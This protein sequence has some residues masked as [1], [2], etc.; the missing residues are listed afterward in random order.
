MDAIKV[1]AL[2]GLDENGRNCY[3]V[4]INH[5]IIVLDCG[6]SLPD[7]NIPGVDFLLPNFSYLIKN[8]ERI[9]GYVLTHGH[10]ENMSALKYFYKQ[11]PAPIYCTRTTKMTFINQALSQGIDVKGIDFIEVIPSQSFNIGNHMVHLFQT[12]HNASYSFG[13][14][15]E[16][17][18]GNIVY[19][20]DYIV[21][22]DKANPAYKFD[23]KGL[24][25]IAEQPTLLLMSESKMAGVPGYCSPKHR[26]TPLIERYFKEEKKKIFISCYWQNY[27]RIHEITKLC[28]ENHKKIY[29]Y[30]EYTRKT[31]EYLMSADKDLI[32]PTII[33]PKD[34]LLRVKS[35]EA[36]VL[37][38][39]NDADIFDEMTL[40]A[41]GLNDDKLISL[42]SNCIFIHAALP[43]NILETAST[44]AI[45][46]IYKTGCEVIWVKG[47]DI[48]AMHAQQEDIRL[49]LT[50]L[51]PRYYL[52]VRGTFSNMID[53][54]KLAINSGIGLNH[55]S[56]FIL[57]NGM[58]LNVSK[59]GF[60]TVKTAEEA[61][62]ETQAILVDGKGI[63]SISEEAINQRIRLGLDG[64]VI[65]AA[66]ISEKEGRVIAGPDCQMRGFVYVKEAEPVLKFVTNTFLEEINFAFNTNNLDWEKVKKNTIDRCTKF[67]KKENGREP[68]VIPTIIIKD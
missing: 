22:Y 5:D 48:Q 39:G 61:N 13:I 15:I 10:D 49:F 1:F 52:P 26:V 51:K 64:V 16:T 21:E 65:V 32:D 66:T 19:T 23:L 60:A 47:K 41:R 42:D 4:E 17:T 9:I 40:L 58:Q 24:C 68:L 6:T 14:A 29:F 7:K 59:E 55:S 37:I 30:N 18:L 45:D 36:V 2:G 12:C 27:F 53:N 3:V 63:S 8:K 67:I 35:D 44:R 46:E 54:A 43:R 33:I 25:R 28:R 38:L 57:D 31:M 50:L 56:V 62:I 20:G 11:A 34:E